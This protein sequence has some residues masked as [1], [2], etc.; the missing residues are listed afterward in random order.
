MSIKTEGIIIQ[1]RTVGERDR[2]VWVLTR[3]QGVVRAFARRAKELKDSKNAGTGLL[4]YSRLTISKG[5][6]SAYITEAFPQ[7]VFF[8]LRRDLRAL[9][10]AQYFCGLAAEV[11][12]EGV[13][14]AETLRLVLNAL[15]FLSEGSRPPELLKPIVELRML[16]QAGYLPDLIGCAACGRYED[17]RMAF[18]VGRGCLYC[19]EH[20]L[21]NGEAAVFLSPA[22]LHAMRHIA[23]ADFQ[24]LF[25]FTLGEAPLRELAEAAQAYTVHILQKWPQT[26]EFYNS[27]GR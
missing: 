7:E 14:S 8:G 5:R 18:K 2:L 22:A 27:L 12:P 10:L 25:A 11:V 19:G 6:E 13:E 15:H 9:A 3:D 20:Y 16:S 23:Y 1:E 4:C 21:D 17:S 26:L 24:R